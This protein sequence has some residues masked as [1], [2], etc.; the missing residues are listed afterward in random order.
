MHRLIIFRGKSL[1]FASFVVR[2]FV[3]VPLDRFSQF[4]PAIFCFFLCSGLF[5]YVL[6][7]T[8]IA[9]VVLA[10]FCLFFLLGFVFAFFAV[11]NSV[12]HRFALA[13]FA[14]FVYFFTIVCNCAVGICISS[15]LQ[16]LIAQNY[17]Y[18][19]LYPTFLSA[20]S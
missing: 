5:T 2:W 18:Y 6:S 17:P 15:L 14:F 7:I 8:T 9:L 1:T 13:R 10:K 3:S 20:Q 4:P 11:K 16:S 19:T 12:L